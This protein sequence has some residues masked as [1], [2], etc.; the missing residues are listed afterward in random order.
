MTIRSIKKAASVSMVAAMLAVGASLPTLPAVAQGQVQAV[1]RAGVAFSNTVT[2]RAQIESVDTATRTIAF[3]NP[4]GR[5]VHVA[6]ANGAGNLDHIADGTTANVTY[7]EV[8]TIL[9]LRQKGPGSRE[10]RRESAHPSA[11]D[12]EAGRFTLTVVAVDLPNNKVSVVS[13]QGGPV[14]TVSAT[15]IAQKDMLTKI[16]PGDVVIGLTTPLMVTAIAPVK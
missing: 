14:R 4:D 8:V 3:T 15:S 11:T 7:S 9:N 12:I 6:V 13:G 10:A 5:L 1:P 2:T 16:K